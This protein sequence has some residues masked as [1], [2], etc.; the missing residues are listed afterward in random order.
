[1]FG[2]GTGVTLAQEPLKQ[3]QGSD[4]D[5]N[6]EQR[7]EEARWVRAAHAARTETLK[8]RKSSHGLLVSLGST[9]RCAYTCDL[10]TS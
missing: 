4:E 6:K 9:H 5:Q 1:M 10:S 3:D 2:M 8:E 7:R